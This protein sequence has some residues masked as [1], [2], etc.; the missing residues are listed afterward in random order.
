MPMA[1]AASIL[2]NYL[3]KEIQSKQLWFWIHYS[4][5]VLSFLLLIVLFVLAIR[6]RNYSSIKHFSKVHDQ[7][8]L[9]IMIL[10][11]IQVLAGIFRPSVEQ[12]QSPQKVED[13][14]SVDEFVDHSGRDEHGNKLPYDS[15]IL[16]RKKWARMHRVGGIFI[17]LMLAYQF[18]SGIEAY[19]ALFQ[20]DGKVY[21]IFYWIWMGLGFVLLMIFVSLN[22]WKAPH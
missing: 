19:K 22:I 7:L 21:F 12:H 1:I 4:L 3:R 16:K 15:K 10:V 18:Y 17:L 13:E 5:N 8:G 20:V 6:A 14:V 2:R 9:A 11:T